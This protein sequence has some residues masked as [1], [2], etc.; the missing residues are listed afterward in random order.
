M[1]KVRNLVVGCGLSGAV[2]A[3]RVAER[4]GE[5]VLV[6]DRRG[7]VGGNCHDRREEKT[8]ITIHENG[9][10]IFH[11]DNERVWD[12]LGRFT[13]WRDFLLKPKVVIDGVKATLPFNLNTI[14]EVF[15]AERANR[16]EDKLTAAFGR[17]ARV[18]ILT[19]REARDEDL[20]FLGGYVYGKVYEQY[21]IKQWGLRPE[22]IDPSVT[23]R[24]PVVVARD[25]RYF[26]DRHQGIPAAGYTRMIEAILDHPG[27]R[28]ELGTEYDDVR[29]GI[30]C[31]RLF[32][33]GSVDDFFGYA[34]GVLP[35][36]SLRFEKRRL[37][38]EYFQETA[39]VNYPCAPE[40]TRI[41]EHKHFLGEKS[42]ATWISTEYPEAYSPGKN[43]RY[44][45]IRN[46]ANQEMYAR[47]FEAARRL[48][49]VRFLGRLGDYAYCN[50][51]QVV[52]RAL[53][54]ADTL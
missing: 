29:S 28:V 2:I 41:C 26:R 52:E 31:D 15:P 16:L 21:T 39:L 17:D 12:Y 37:E 24:V 33:T 5:E 45:P 42:A 20:R 53:C 47:Y 38:T 50:M 23:A 1:A 3:E 30:A 25:D 48:K 36:R 14:H 18:P 27:I 13:G 32:Y 44:Y 40:F 46:K 10:H 49:G 6:I 35:Y 34:L 7:H 22:E 54:L 8:G 9:P 4:L 19:L 11:T 43:E 51:D